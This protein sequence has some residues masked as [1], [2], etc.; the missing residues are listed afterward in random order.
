MTR[1][2]WNRRGSQ[3]PM[4]TGDVLSLQVQAASYLY[5]GRLEQL[6]A[7][8]EELRGIVSLMA[9]LLSHQ[10]QRDLINGVTYD[11]TEMK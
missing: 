3:H 10:Q 7:E 2:M 4:D 9:N 11:I 8:L 6:Q 5:P 1:I